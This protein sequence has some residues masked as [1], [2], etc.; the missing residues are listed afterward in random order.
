MTKNIIKVLSSSVV[1]Q[2]LTMLVTLVIIRSLS[3]HEFADYSFY[4]GLSAIVSGFLANVINRYIVFSDTYNIVRFSYRW[5]YLI[6]AILFFVFLNNKQIIIISILISLH[7]VIFEVNRT[8]YQ[9]KQDFT[10][11][12]VSQVFKSIAFLFFI[13][14][15]FF[16]EQLTTESSLSSIALSLLLANVIFLPSVN[17][18]EIRLFGMMKGVFINNEY[19]SL[20]FIIIHIMSQ[21][22]QWFLRFGVSVEE[23]GYFSLAF[24]IYTISMLMVA[25]M[26]KVFIS[27]LANKSYT[28]CINGIKKFTW[29]ITAIAAFFSLLT[30]LILPYIGFIINKDVE[31]VK[32]PL[33]ILL[34]S[35]VFS[36]LLSP[37]SEVLQKHLKYKD[38]FYS[39]LLALSTMF[40]LGFILKF[41]DK[42]SAVSFSMIYLISYFVLNYSIYMR[43]K[44]CT[45][46]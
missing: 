21:S 24:Y 25:S 33:F 36:I 27:E 10:K 30:F 19:L 9:K 11:Y 39:G 42:G 34:S 2:F 45:H 37:Y 13:I 15:L 20:Y 32:W 5:V 23:Q 12:G 17:R 18:K 40:L 35:S 26:K 6:S 16:M 7:M 31:N 8:Y 43:S 44:L 28:E 14:L 46:Y 41:L 1:A 3:L 38:L 4:L 22:S 29:K